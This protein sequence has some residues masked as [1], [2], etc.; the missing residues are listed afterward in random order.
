MITQIHNLDMQVADSVG[1]TVN[2]ISN[3]IA[4]GPI[5]RSLTLSKLQISVQ[6]LIHSLSNLNLMKEM[7]TLRLGSKLR[8]QQP[9]LTLNL[10]QLKQLPFRLEN[11][12][13]AHQLLDAMY[14]SK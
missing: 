6:H 4:A 14:I 9:P 2:A 5:S 8:F 1:L 10:P 3:N 11:S 13:L 7:G 12:L